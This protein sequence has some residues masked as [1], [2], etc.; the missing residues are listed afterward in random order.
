MSY[1]ES[2]KTMPY[3]L[4]GSSGNRVGAPSGHHDAYRSKPLPP[5]QSSPYKGEDARAFFLP[6]N[7]KNELTPEDPH[8]TRKSHILIPHFF[9]VDFQKKW[10]FKD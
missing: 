1:S 9:E 10:P 4:I 8:K 6:D 7:L 2:P 3:Y 5:P